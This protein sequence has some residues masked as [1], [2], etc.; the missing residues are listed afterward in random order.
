MQK[1]HDCWSLNALDK[2]VTLFL[3]PK[4]KNSKNNRVTKDKLEILMKKSIAQKRV[5]NL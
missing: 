3:T 5:S 2:E 1:K 4:T